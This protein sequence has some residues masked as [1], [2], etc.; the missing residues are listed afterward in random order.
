MKRNGGILAFLTIMFSSLTTAGPVEGVEQLASGAREVLSIAIQFITDVF[1]DL[2]SF[3]EFLFAKL[4]ILL[5]IFFV[6]YTILRRNDMFGRDKRIAIIITSAISILSVRYLPNEFVQAI[7]LQYNVF[8]V[9]VT[10][11]IPIIIFFF[12]LHQSG[13]RSFGRKSGW[14]LYGVALISLAGFRYED[15]GQAQYIYYAAI[16]VIIVAYIFDRA[17]HTKFNLAGLKEERAAHHLRRLMENKKKI[18]DYQERIDE[19]LSGEIKRKAE[20]RVEKLLRDNI[21]LAKH[22]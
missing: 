20:K 12:F 15:L 6:V 21:E 5:I 13:F 18:K 2:D 17:I 3:D 22:I 10:T 14:A 11:F 1:F 9:A 8:A 16:V 4:I 7:L 19:G